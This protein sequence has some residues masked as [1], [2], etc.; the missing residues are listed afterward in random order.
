MDNSPGVGA[1]FRIGRKSLV[2]TQ[3]RD[4][5]SRNRCV[6][7]ACLPVEPVPTFFTLTK[8]RLRMS[9]TINRIKRS[10][11][12][13]RP[14][15]ALQL[16][17]FEDEYCL[18]FFGFLIALPFMDRWHRVPED[19]M[20]SWGFYYDY[21]NASLVI[22]RG[23]KAKFINMPWQYD[24][25]NDKHMVQLEDGSWEPCRQSYEPGGQ[26]NRFIQTFPYTYIL[27]NGLAQNV[28]ATV[29]VDR[30]EWRRKCLR[31]IPWF[32]MKRQSLDV[33][34]SAEVGERVGSWKGGC[35]GCGI[36]MKKGE[37]AEQALRRMERER[38]FD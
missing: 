32:A 6:G 2:S 9:S 10:L 31:Y 1:S 35:I 38:K 7:K 14:R 30:R 36:D 33:T 26:D 29:Y 18:C 8:W 3:S 12:G 28:K 17:L 16:D 23:K 27:K 15:F 25:M 24:H 22:C 4:Q 19:C 20:E 34:F 11:R 21:H 37:T 5:H 13:C